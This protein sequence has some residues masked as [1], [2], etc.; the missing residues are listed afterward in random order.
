MKKKISLYDKHW[1]I[2]IHEDICEYEVLVATLTD[3]GI[4]GSSSLTGE[5]LDFVPNGSKVI[6]L[7]REAKSL[8]D[9]GDKERFFT[10]IYDESKLSNFS[11]GEYVLFRHTD[12]F[13]EY[14]KSISDIRVEIEESEIDVHRI[15]R[16]IIQKHSYD[17]D[18]LSDT[19]SDEEYKTFYDEICTKI[20]RIF[21]ILPKQNYLDLYDKLKNYV[22]DESGKS[23]LLRYFV[24]DESIDKSIDDEK[25][26]IISNLFM[27]GIDCVVSYMREA[28]GSDY[29][30]EK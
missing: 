26:K 30:G 3:D 22:L 6:D 28:Y 19:L 11:V 16:E 18:I 1:L 29:I 2:D 7:L 13:D 14:P 21:D 12:I 23:S 17:N 25:A 15:V 27:L 24:P 8:W 10:L 4:V 5:I 20:S 9:S